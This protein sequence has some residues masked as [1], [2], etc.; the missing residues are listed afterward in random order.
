MFNEDDLVLITLTNQPTT[1]KI[2]GLIRSGE[3]IIDKARLHKSYR[4]SIFF[5]IRNHFSTC[6]FFSSS[7]DDHP[8]VK[9]TPPVWFCY[10]YNIRIF[11][12]GMKILDGS[13]IKIKV[14]K[15]LITNSMNKILI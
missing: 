8:D 14:R 12:N 15:N 7:L 13:K 9:I 1:N 4:R 2:F 10:E 3:R 11:G 5:P 6:S